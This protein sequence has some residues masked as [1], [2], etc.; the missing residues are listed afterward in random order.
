[1]GTGSR[2]LRRPLGLGAAQ[3]RRLLPPLAGLSSRVCA[4]RSRRLPVAE[5]TRPPPARRPAPPRPARAPRLG[6]QRP[7]AAGQ[8]TAA[9]RG[10]AGPPGPSGWPWPAASSL[11]GRCPFRALLRAILIE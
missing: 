3:R 2:W 1:M 8:G 5:P 11:L 6:P 7:A 4:P 10:E 9:A